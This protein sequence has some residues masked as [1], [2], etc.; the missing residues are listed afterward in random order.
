M[1]REF[2]SESGVVELWTSDR[3]P[4]FLYPYCKAV[5]ARTVLI[6]ADKK[7][8]IGVSVDVFPLDGLDDK[9]Q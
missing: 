1:I 4:N 7:H 8:A 6:E 3:T 9:L 5:D 2:Y